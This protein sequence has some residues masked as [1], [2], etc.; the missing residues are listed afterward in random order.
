[1]QLSLCPYQGTLTDFPSDFTGAVF[2]K[3]RSTLTPR[4]YHLLLQILWIFFTKDTNPSGAENTL[5]LIWASVP[6]PI[7]IFY[8]V[9]NALKHVLGPEEMKDIYNFYAKS[10]G[11]EVSKC[12]PRSLK[13]L[14]RTMIRRQ[15]C[16]KDLWLPDIINK[17]DIPKTLKEFL[18][19][20]E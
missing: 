10:V 12:E 4:R 11:I 13:Q 20:D 18:N 3:I 16:S 15:I 14:C 9:E 6:D 1:M 5:R 19:L 8:E 2:T 17:F 7:I